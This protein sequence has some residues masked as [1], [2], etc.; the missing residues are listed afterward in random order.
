[1]QDRTLLRIGSVMAIAGALLAVA[2]LILHPRV[3]EL[4]YGKF[5]YEEE[6]LQNIADHQEW[7]TVHLA[8]LF[9]ALFMAGA[10]FAIQRSITTEPAAAWAQLGFLS[11]LLGTGIIVANIAVDGLALK[12]VADA[13]ADA[14]SDERIT[15]FRIGNSMVEIALALFSVWLIVF[16][17]LT[18]MLYGLAVA[19]STAYPKWLGWIAATAGSAGLVIGLFHSFDG[20]SILVSNVLFSIVAV[21][22][23]VWMVLMAAVMWRKTAAAGLETAVESPRPMLA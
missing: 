1:M 2:S 4:N 21:V 14:P 13:W 9:A 6:F 19:V 15:F 17:G 22:L 16:W 5:G 20:P 7:V 23:I 18:F 11:A 3:G 8:V 10:L 12:V